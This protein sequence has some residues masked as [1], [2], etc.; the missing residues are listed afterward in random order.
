M[1]R[2]FLISMFI[3]LSRRSYVD[4]KDF[5]KAYGYV[6]YSAYSIVPDLAQLLPAINQ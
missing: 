5:D 4:R 1:T 2:Y 6:R 3:L